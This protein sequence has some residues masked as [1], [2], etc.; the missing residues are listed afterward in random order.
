M[1]TCG[2]DLDKWIAAAS[3]YEILSLAIRM[4]QG[5]ART[6][7]GMARLA[8]AAVAKAKF[9]YLA[10]EEREHARILGKARAATPRPSRV[11]KLPVTVAEVS[12]VPK[13]KSSADAVRLAIQAEREAELFYTACAARCRRAKAR[14]MFAFLANQ[15]AGHAAALDIELKALRGPQPWSSMEGFIP[16]ENDYWG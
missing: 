15:E 8:L 14:R 12:G 13:G 10:E 16:E 11:Q 6:Y 3:A 9:R 5:A 7:A 2:K 4:E 1:K